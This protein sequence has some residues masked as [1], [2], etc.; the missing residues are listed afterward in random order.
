MESNKN[1]ISSICKIF[2]LLKDY[3]NEEVLLNNIKDIINSEKI[4]YI[5]NPKR[6]PE[7]TKEVNEC[8]YMM[9][10]SL[11]LSVLQ[12][13]NA[14]YI[15]NYFNEK[16][17]NCLN[18]LKNLNKDLL[19]YLDEIFSFNEFLEISN[20]LTKN[21][22]CFSLGKEI[23][24]IRDIII[25]NIY[26]L[27]SNDFE[28]LINQ[29]SR[30]YVSITD[31]LQ[32]NHCAELLAKIYQQEFEKILDI[33]YRERIFCY[34]LKN[35]KIIVIS[36]GI[37]NMLFK[38]IIKVKDE[39]F[40]KSIDNILE[41][42]NIIF[43][44]I[45][46]ILKDAHTNSNIKK[47]YLVLE[48]TL[49]YF[50]EKNCFI[51]LSKFLNV[52]KKIFLDSDIILNFFKECLQ[53]LIVF[54]ST[55]KYVNYKMNICKLFCLAFIKSYCY[56]FIFF[57]KNKSQKLQ[58]KERIIE[59]I[60]Q[61]KDL[62]EEKKGKKGKKDKEKNLA[63]QVIKELQIYIFKT[64]YY[65][66]KR[67]IFLFSNSVINEYLLN[68]YCFF[69]D[70][71]SLSKKSFNINYPIK[72]EDNK[73]EIEFNNKFQEYKL[74][75]FNNI[76]INDFKNIGIDLIYMNSIDLILSYLEEEKKNENYK[77]L[78]NF[79]NNVCAPLFDQKIYNSLQLFYKPEKFKAFL[80]SLKITGISKVKI[81]I[82]SYRYFLNEIY[83]DKNS[84]YSIFYDKK[85][86]S[87]IDKYFYPGNDIRKNISYYDLWID[88]NKQIKNENKDIYYCLYSCGNKH[89]TRIN[90]T[91]NIYSIKI[92]CCKICKNSK[93]YISN[94]IIKIKLNE[95]KNK[96]R[97]YE[98][99][100]IKEFEKKYIYEYFKDEIGITTDTDK[101]HLKQENK[102]IRNLNQISYRLL[103]FILYS[104][105]FMAKIFTNNQQ[106]EKYLPKNMN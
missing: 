2:S 66:N 49:L 25:E 86:F 101:N 38:L 23:L 59:E 21:K 106:L 75:E 80:S 61:I 20:A 65:I 56:V 1:Y 29:I 41:T 105:L 42:D 78:N 16:L 22:S 99:L 24:E 57:I 15:N 83:S 28:K 97:N 87:N 93:K 73:T 84:I 10:G 18:I 79:F 14:G 77:A 44:E 3:I 31:H 85:K 82:Y 102:I 67:N 53:K 40:F 6:N 11:C 46:E 33:N 94:N 9:L 90:N 4:K 72:E 32:F 74:D 98:L 19:L 70:L 71:K 54:L 26:Y 51:F 12:C 13:Y 89:W 96:I 37:F 92:S 36:K 30:L 52:K 62:F 8:F 17:R 47:N 39:K 103:N 88:I 50:F 95:D 100:T 60:N 81:L 63:E 48:E 43:M 45:E 34:L 58:N 64:V 7:N 68:K 104:H 5:T 69:E 27:Q 76:K 35:N 91:Y 55:N